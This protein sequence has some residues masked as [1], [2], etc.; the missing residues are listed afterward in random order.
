[1]QITFKAWAQAITRLKITVMGYGAVLLDHF[2]LV[3]HNYLKYCKDIL[4]C[5]T[6]YLLSVGSQTVTFYFKLLS[7]LIID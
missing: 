3:S 7:V 1:M 2:L 6:S 5:S 4:K